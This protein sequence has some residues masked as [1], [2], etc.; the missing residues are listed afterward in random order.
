[1]ASD[2]PTVIL[3]SLAVPQGINASLGIPPDSAPYWLVYLVSSFGVICLQ[4]KLHALYH[5]GISIFWGFEWYKKANPIDSLCR[6]G[7]YQRAVSLT[8]HSHSCARSFWFRAA[9]IPSAITQWH[10][11]S[12]VLSFEYQSANPGLPPE[13]LT[14][15]L[16]S[17]HATSKPFIYN[18]PR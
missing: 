6:R 8:G 13:T 15:I 14:V 7:N 2:C 17:A 10:P 4:T 11:T 18:P 12:F 9:C 1:M 3:S 16:P 5:S